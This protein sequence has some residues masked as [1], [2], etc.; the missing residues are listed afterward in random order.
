MKKVLYLALAVALTA[1]VTSCK[2]GGAGASGLV[3]DIDSLSY[4]MGMQYAQGLDQYLVQ[5]GLDTNYVNEFYRGMK[6]AFKDGGN[7][8]KEAYNLGVSLGYQLYTRMYKG[9]SEHVFAGDSTQSLNDKKFLEGFITAAKKGQTL[10]TVEDAHIY[11]QTKAE[12]VQHRSIEKMFA[13]NKADGEKFLADNAKK[14]GVVTLPSGVQYKILKEGTGALVPDSVQ[15]EVNYEG[16]LIDGTVFDSSY[17]RKHTSTMMAKGT[18]PGFSE[19][20]TR[21]PIGSTWE[22][23]I[24]QDKAYGERNMGK[25]KP[26]STLI[27]KLE[28]VGLKQ[29]KK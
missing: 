22:V 25:I 16:R 8:K 21:M 19:V 9:S 2:K 10:F 5:M 1:G 23:Y 17:E 11:A 26:F 7:N 20:L 4:A 3:N 6:S 28:L 14:P 13:A 18:I 29:Q 24:P 12:E 15:V 27:F